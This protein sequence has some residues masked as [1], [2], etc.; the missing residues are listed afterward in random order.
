MWITPTVNERS[1][2]SRNTSSIDLIFTSHQNLVMES[3]V[4]TSLHN[5]CYHQITS[6]KFKL[7]IYSPPYDWEVWLYQKA[8]F[9]ISEKR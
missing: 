4:Q 7:K 2:L 5:N 3:E 9:E 6:A 1:Q 8:N